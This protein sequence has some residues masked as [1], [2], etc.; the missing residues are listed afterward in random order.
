MFQL[1]TDAVFTPE[2]ALQ[3]TGAML[4]IARVD[5]DGTEEEVAMI[6]EFYTGF[7][8]DVVADLPA[9]DALLENTVGSWPAA[10]LF[11]EAAQ[12][13]MLVSTCIMVAFADGRLSEQELSAL[14][15]LARAV[16]LPEA[17][18]AEL[19]ELVKDHMLMQLA[20]LPDAQSI[21]AVAAELG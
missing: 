21:A 11:P 10:E 14:H 13:E 15:E 12:R 19:L 20:G 18:F 7:Q 6:R 17:R 5:P 16:Q 2:Q 9:F 1:L 3:M 8:D 4:V